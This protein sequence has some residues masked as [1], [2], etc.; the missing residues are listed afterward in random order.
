M[1]DGKTSK[2]RTIF[3]MFRSKPEQ[4]P[5]IEMMTIREEKKSLMRII[6][7]KP[8]AIKHMS[9]VLETNVLT[10]QD[11]KITKAV[12]QG[13]VSAPSSQKSSKITGTA[14]PPNPANTFS[15]LA[16]GTKMLMESDACPRCHTKYIRG[17]AL[18][19]LAEL[20]Q[21]ESTPVG[22][23]DYGDGDDL[24]FDGSPI[25]HFDAV[26]GVI[27]YFEHQEGESDFELECGSCGTLIQL[28]IDRC[29][30]CGAVL[31]TTDIG[32]LSLIRDSDFDGESFSE[33]ECPLC[34]DHVILCDGRCPA[35]ESVIVDPALETP[36]KKIIP[37]IETEN[38]VFV[39]IDLETGDLNFLQ[40]HLNRMAIEHMSIQL[41]GI[42]NDGFDEDWQ[43]LSRI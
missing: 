6:K 38:V 32:V 14:A 16:C 43:G 5:E 18:G 21:A 31:D 35:C 26:D 17:V 3:D 30:I 20:E 34:G 11:M 15:C 12:M 4:E 19:A 29:P 41:D 36:G 25:I 39:H 13:V 40:R 23:D 33:L 9:E 24:D 37:L 8:R 1:T 10:E 42:G 2:K 22:D 28:D 27:S 7:A